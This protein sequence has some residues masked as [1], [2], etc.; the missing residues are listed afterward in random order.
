MVTGVG[1]PAGKAGAIWFTR[2]G[3]RVVATDMVEIETPAPAFRIVPAARHPSFGDALVD[4]ARREGARLLVC[5]VSEELPVVARLRP[6]LR[7]I[8]CALSISDPP[9]IDVADDKLE[10]ARALARAGVAVPRTFATTDRGEA[11]AALGFPLL[12]KPRVGRGGRGVLVHR[13]AE[14]LERVQ[15]EVI[16]QEFLPGEEFDVNLFAERDGSAPAAVVLRKTALK[17]GLVGNATGVERVDRPDIAR[18]AAGAAR[19]LRLEGPLDL[20]ARTRTDGSAAVLEVNARLGANVLAAP[21]VLDAFESAWRAG[22][23]D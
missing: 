17:E 11:V 18:L 9:G 4:L 16:W 21:E 20:D 7:A 22:R 23:C 13:S 1:G 19:A 12:S 14:D 15:G 10:T 8:G 5:T 2:R 6:R 3:Y